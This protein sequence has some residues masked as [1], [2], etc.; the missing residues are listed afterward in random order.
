MLAKAQRLTAAEVREILK[1]GRSARSG[2][3]SAKYTE[4]KRSKAAV[5]VSKK[6]AK[7]AVVR[8]KLRRAAYAALSPVLP[9]RTNLVLFLHKPVLDPA[10]VATLCSKLS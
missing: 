8:N 5:V 3:L 10:E 2:T 9:A 7:T 6:V 1:S 4:S